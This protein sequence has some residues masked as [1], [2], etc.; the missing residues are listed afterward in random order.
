M[1]FK[2]A[3]IIRQLRLGGAEKQL[4][5]LATE[6]PRWNYHPCV[7]ALSGG[8]WEKDLRARNVETFV[9]SPNG[10]HSVRKLLQIV[11]IL[12]SFKPEIVYGFDYS[13][14]IYGRLAGAIVGIPILIGGVQSELMP[15]SWVIYA[16]RA[17][18]WKTDAIISNSFA[19]KRTWTELLGYPPE[20]VAVVLNGFN[21]EEMRQFPKGQKQYPSFS[22][23][24][25]LYFNSHSL[26]CSHRYTK[27]RLRGHSSFLL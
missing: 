8:E 14:S 23:L 26:S 3:L 22:G 4:V 6:L 18:R 16:D 17:L 27:D 7:I 15:Q 9:L 24:S 1:S 13:G 25:E 20:K 2:I 11:K 21:F 5:Q 10:S 12:R 19:G